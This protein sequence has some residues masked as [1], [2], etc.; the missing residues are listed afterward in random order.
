MP[1][2]V[3]ALGERD[4]DPVGPGERIADVHDRPGRPDDEAPAGPRHLDG[5]L[6]DDP[7]QLLAVEGGAERLA[8]VVG[9]VPQATAFLLEVGEALLQLLG[10][11]VERVAEGGELVPAVHVDPLVQSPGRDRVRRRRELREAADDRATGEVRDA[12]DQRY[13]GEQPGEQAGLEAALLRVEQALRHGGDEHRTG[14]VVEG[15]AERAML[16]ALER[17]RAEHAGHQR[18][19]V[20]EQETVVLGKPRAR[21]QPREQLLVERDAD[22]DRR[23]PPRGRRR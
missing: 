6:H 15:D 1:K 4:V 16:P 11:V 19:V 8:E 20:D 14:R 12:A 3:C 23:C 13:G 18:P 7:Q 21:P 22:G 10:H 17:R 2:V 9:R 5:R